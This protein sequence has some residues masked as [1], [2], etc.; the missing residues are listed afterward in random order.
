MSKDKYDRQTRL[1]GEGQI[2]IS[3]SKLLCLNS[4]S[5]SSEILKNLILSGVGEV[6]IIDKAS[7]TKED[8]KTNFFVD[9]DD[10]GKSRAEI[11]LKNL[12]ELNPDVKGNFIEKTAKE[13][14]DDNNND[15]DINTINTNTENIGSNISNYSISSKDKD[16]QKERNSKS[17]GYDFSSERVTISSLN[18]S[19]VKNKVEENY[20]KSEDKEIHKD[21]I[22]NF[23][24]ENKDIILE[25]GGFLNEKEN[26]IYYMGIID[27]LTN[28]D[29][30]K[31]GEFIYKSIRYCSKKMSCISP[32]AYQERF[33]SYLK[34]ILPPNYTKDDK[35][36]EN[37]K[38]E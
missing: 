25:D 3:N 26:E 10:I 9:L 7:I 18:K 22:D 23:I 36:E 34:Q 1:W 6:T 29:C 37:I 16:S 17:M 24:N 8:T 11:V 30:V 32:D 20:I 14:L 35:K 12:L 27:I 38:E 13:F 5:L 4:D 33:M 28:Y 31:V 15:N 19:F 21:E 2:L